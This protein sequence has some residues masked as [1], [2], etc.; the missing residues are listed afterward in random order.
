MVKLRGKVPGWPVQ[1]TAAVPCTT[2]AAEDTP[3]S[4]LQSSDAAAVVAVSND[5][6]EDAWLH[7]P[8]TRNQAEERARAMP[9]GLTEGMFLVRPANDAFA[10]MM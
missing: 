8:I 2:G 6:G 4:D 7:G 5:R 10:L 9:G 3:A 1:L